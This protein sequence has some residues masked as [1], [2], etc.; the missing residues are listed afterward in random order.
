MAEATFPARG[1]AVVRVSSRSGAVTI[2]GEERDTILVEKGDAHLD[3]EGAVEVA[4]GSGRVAIRCPTGT[5]VL[6]GTGSGRVKLHGHL[7]DARITTGSGAIT[8]EAVRTVDARTGSGSIEV[9]GCAGDCQLKTGSGKVRL[10][11]AGEASIATGSGSVRADAV[12]GARVRA[13]SGSVVIGLTAA[14]PVDVEAHSGSVTLTVPAGLRPD[15][16][17]R[18]GSG[19]VRC[20][21]PPGVD[22]PI[23]VTTGSGGITVA[24]R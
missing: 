23:R 4:G 24:E 18:A 13:G 19:T 3:R 10:G 1:H 9:D 16:I 21:C 5:D 2:T 14:G 8:V 22:C 11:V 12:R 17:L 6:V 15:A 7:G 20:D